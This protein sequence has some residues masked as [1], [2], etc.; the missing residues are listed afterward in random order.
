MATAFTSKFGQRTKRCPI[1]SLGCHV[2]VFLPHYVTAALTSGEQVTPSRMESTSLACQSPGVRNLKWLCSSYSLKSNS[3]LP[4]PLVG[5]PWGVK[6]KPAEP[7][8]VGREKHKF[9]GRGA[10]S[11]GKRGHSHCH[12]LV[13][14]ALNYLYWGHCIL[15]WSLMYSVYCSLEATRAQPA[16]HH[17]TTL[18][19]WHFWVCGCDRT[20][21]SHDHVPTA[22][23]LL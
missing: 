5:F 19:G 18:L 1:T 2:D 14:W 13:P 16:T 12:L 23:P 6:T 15:Q 22:A 17:S 20:C 4:L 10:G 21:G 9:I 3:T 11:D 8:G 7:R